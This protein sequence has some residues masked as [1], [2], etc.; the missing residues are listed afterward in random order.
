MTETKTPRRELTDIDSI[1]LVQRL[2]KLQAQSDEIAGEIESLK[3]ELR[4]RL[5][6]GDYTLDGRPAV[7][8][9]QTRRLDVDKA[10]GMLPVELR[11]LARSTSYDVRKLREYL[12]P[13]FIAECMVETGNPS[14]RVL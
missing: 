12:A 2:A 7:R 4:D 11:E 6:I 1:G 9:T 14:V 5:D 3:T 10:A 8:I 13:A